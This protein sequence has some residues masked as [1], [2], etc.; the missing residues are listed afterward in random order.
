[1][2]YVIDRLF[3]ILFSIIN[4]VGSI[5]I[6]AKAPILYDTLEPLALP[7]SPIRPLGG[8][9]LTKQYL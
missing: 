5:V 8:D 9:V 6:V 2:A 3:F 7:K 4:I 1:M